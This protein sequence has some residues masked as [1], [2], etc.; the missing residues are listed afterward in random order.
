MRVQMT[1]HTRE[2]DWVLF[3]GQA[4]KCPWIPVEGNVIRYNDSDYR[5]EGVQKTQIDGCLHIGL[6]A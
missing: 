5:V 1:L 3:E 2:G 6:L 4:E